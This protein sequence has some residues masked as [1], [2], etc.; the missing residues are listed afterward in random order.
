MTPANMGGD[1]R[2]VVELVY[3]SFLFLLFLIAAFEKCGI[4]CA[5]VLV[6]KGRN[7]WLPG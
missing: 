3:R 7:E 1:M 2:R 4:C 5:C 6:S